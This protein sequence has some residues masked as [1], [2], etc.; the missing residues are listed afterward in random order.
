MRTRV[1]RTDDRPA[2]DGVSGGS[3]VDGATDTST[4]RLPLAPTNILRGD[5]VVS[6]KSARRPRATGERRDIVIR[7]GRAVIRAR[8]LDTP[9]ADRIWT[10]MPIYSA[11]NIWG[12][13]IH[14]ETHV[15]TGREPAATRTLKPGEIGYWVE[16]DRVI[17]PWGMTP[18]SKIGECRMPSPVN[19]WAVALDDVAVLA[20][21]RPAERVSIL[22][23]DS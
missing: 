11:A 4:D 17:I 3:G 16:D 10:Q 21:V 19:V 12:Q 13:S 6:K 14:F 18:L 5:N 7:A 22:A 9:T 8:L 1:E 15:E 20:A 23:A 2:R